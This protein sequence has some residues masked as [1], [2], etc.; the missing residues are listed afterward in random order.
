MPYEPLPKALPMPMWP[1]CMSQLEMPEA[2]PS[3][4]RR[5]ARPAVDGD[6]ADPRLDEPPGQE[7]V[8]PQGM[9][10]VAVA[11]VRGLAVQLEHLPPARAARQLEG[12]AVQFLPIP[13]R[14]RL[15]LAGALGRVQA[16]PATGG[17]PPC[18]PGRPGRTARPAP[19]NRA[20]PGGWPPCR[21]TAGRAAGRG[22][23]R[24]RCSRR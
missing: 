20:W 5:R 24:C 10:A 3:R 12:P 15:P 18:A 23:R 19:R 4:L 9:P 8:L 17:G 16:V 6:E 21:R 1:P 2:P 7:Q 22:S 14:G 13:V 11:H